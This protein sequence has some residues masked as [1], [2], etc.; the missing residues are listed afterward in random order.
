MDNNQMQQI[1][2]TR[3]LKMALNNEL[4]A[5]QLQLLNADKKLN[6]LYESIKIYILF[7][8]APLILIL[9]LLGG[10]WISQSTALLDQMI[11]NL[12]TGLLGLL[13]TIYCIMALP[14]ALYKLIETCILLKINQND[15]INYAWTKPKERPF[16]SYFHK[17]GSQENTSTYKLEQKKLHWV[18]NQ[19]LLQLETLENLEKDFQAGFYINQPEQFDIDISKIVFYEP[20]PPSTPYSETQNKAK[21]ITICIIIGLILLV[22]ALIKIILF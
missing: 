5:A 4:K 1:A 22:I 6:S 11:G 3:Q 12:V 16:S 19:Y 20:I 13:L 8:L 18:I 15:E 9:L 7:C 10:M 2:K 21:R 14:Y 17:T